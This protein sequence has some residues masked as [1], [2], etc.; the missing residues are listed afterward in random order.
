ME[1]RATTTV[2]PDDALTGPTPGPETLA[3]VLEPLPEPPTKRSGAV[4]RLSSR[5]L[6]I[7]AVAGLLVLASVVFALVLFRR[8][9][10]A[11]A[12]GNATQVQRVP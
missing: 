8:Q 6:I 10:N 3:S 12:A 2:V 7:V 1:R 5:T 9:S 11:R 4:A